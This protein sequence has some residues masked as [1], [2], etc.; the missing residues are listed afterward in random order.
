MLRKPCDTLALLASSALTKKIS[1]D[2]P[3]TVFQKSVDRGMQT[4]LSCLSN[5]ENQLTNN[6]VAQDNVK[7]C[8]K[9]NYIPETELTFNVFTYRV[10]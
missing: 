4:V 8:S 1:I 2:A 3:L 10:P 6:L 7:V 5:P 9:Q